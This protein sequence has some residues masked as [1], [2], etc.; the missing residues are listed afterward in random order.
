MLARKATVVIFL[1]LTFSKAVLTNKETARF[2]SQ[3]P[4]KIFRCHHSKTE[5]IATGGS[6]DQKPAAIPTGK[7]ATSRKGVH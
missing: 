7:Q 4:I 6:G 1:L 5:L 2:G 3:R